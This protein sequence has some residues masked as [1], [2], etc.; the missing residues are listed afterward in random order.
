[1]CK[2]ILCFSSV[3]ALLLAYAV[4]TDLL[5]SEL[6]W[7]HDQEFPER[8]ERSLAEVRRLLDE[9]KSP[10]LATRQKKYGHESFDDHTYNDKFSLV[11]MLTNTALAATMAIFDRLGVNEDVLY[12]MKEWRM[13]KKTVT[14]GFNGNLS[15]ANIDRTKKQVEGPTSEEV[16]EI[17]TAN[18]NSSKTT[19]T[20]VVD[21]VDGY[22]HG[23]DVQYKFEVYSGSLQLSTEESSS[24]PLHERTVTFNMTTEMPTIPKQLYPVD[25]LSSEINLSWFLDQMNIIDD[26]IE[27]AFVINRTE[28][29]CRTPTRNSEVSNALNLF[30]AVHKW[31]KTSEFFSSLKAL[32]EFCRKSMDFSH[33]RSFEQVV[34]VFDPVLPIFVDNNHTSSPILQNHD[35]SLLLNEHIKSLNMG[36]D[37]I[38]KSDPDQQ[39]LNQPFSV[40]DAR[41]S[42]LYTQLRNI[43]KS[44]AHQMEAIE[45]MIW[46]QMHQA[47]GKHLSPANFED[48]FRSYVKKLFDT[49]FLPEPFTYAVRRTDHYP[50]GYVSLETVSLS[51]ES[52]NIPITTVTRKLDG[53]QNPI[54]IPLNAAINIEFGG[55]RYLHAWVIHSFDGGEQSNTNIV[56]RARQFSS[57]VLLVGN[58]VGKNEFDPK[59]AI[60]LQNKDEVM[61]PLLLETIP[62]PK[63]FTDA[64]E[65][66]SPEQQQFAKA[67]RAMQLE[68]SVLG[69]CVIQLKPQ[70]EAV[71]NLPPDSLT[72]EIRLTQDILSLFIDYQIPPDLIS[73]DLGEDAAVKEKLDRV[74]MNVDVIHSLIDD[75]K[76]KELED[77]KRKAE[78]ENPRIFKAES[79]FATESMMMDSMADTSVKFGAN[80]G[81][82][83]LRRSTALYG[84]NDDLQEAEIISDHETLPQY[85]VSYDLD[86]SDIDFLSIPRIL[87]NKIELLDSDSFLRSTKITVGASWTLAT[88][89]NLLSDRAVQHLS[90]IQQAE[91]RNKAFDL[92]DAITKS[93]SLKILE[94]ELHILVAVTHQ[95]DR[96]V[97]ETVIEENI[98]PIEKL[99]RSLLV[100]QSAIHGLPVQ[101]ILK[102]DMA[103]RILKHSPML[104]DQAEAEELSRNP[105][106]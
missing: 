87:D 41:V 91:E 42:F 54:S 83:G 32:D 71:L 9:E 69:I 18:G 72:K 94:A 10:R 20:R 101:K 51:S 66:L 2:S 63:A 85:D 104:F 61:I 50:D 95:F 99:E 57:F 34:N 39:S 56:A 67:F 43:V 98:N 97:M 15:C 76:K 81:S 46:K 49:R 70:L 52:S 79:V 4:A 37:H 62:T 23:C 31:A 8:L 47:I 77:A 24:F 93:G 58:I 106:H 28:K 1:M 88:Q 53:R 19:K 84:Q 59:H 27:W 75:A 82:R 11:Q 38:T 103:Q 26:K 74:K 96:S 12:K 89:A 3:F 48:F 65:S 90:N 105:H 86:D 102:K 36:L 14:L 55:S 44:Y 22:I 29:T 40:V 33:P 64:I 92:L 7:I 5:P 13:K 60:I 35:L 17:S 68:S 100:V 80:S 78:Y 45:D 25:S 30:Q 21:I 6:K 16:R 73:S